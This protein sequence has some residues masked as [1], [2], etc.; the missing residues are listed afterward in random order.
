MLSQ[1]FN[2]EKTQSIIDVMPDIM[3]VWKVVTD[4]RYL[5]IRKDAKS[6]GMKNDQWHPAFTFGGDRTFWYPFKSGCN[7]NNIW[8][9]HCFVKKGEVQQYK[10]YF[11]HQNHI[12]HWNMISAK[13]E[14]KDIMKIG[15]DKGSSLTILASRIIMPAYPNTDIAKEFTEGCELI[16]N[17]EP[18]IELMSDNLSLVDANT[19]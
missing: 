5:N 15:L 6:R 1:I 12:G 19:G 3:I 9:F 11:K 7:E 16:E 8:G 18:A 10:K 17:C 14:K 2:K 13:I 4:W